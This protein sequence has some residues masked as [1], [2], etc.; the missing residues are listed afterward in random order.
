MVNLN[1]VMLVKM[2][3]LIKIK[4]RI[5]LKNITENINK[6][7]KIYRHIFYKIIEL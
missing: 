1:Q 4:H 6:I 7:A 5:L 2:K 3:K